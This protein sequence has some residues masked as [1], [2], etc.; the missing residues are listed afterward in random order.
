MNL[1]DMSGEDVKIH[2]DMLAIPQFDKVWKTYEDKDQSI[3]F[4]KYVILNNYPLSPYVKSYMSGDRRVLLEKEL[5]YDMSV[6]PDLLSETEQVF[7][8]LHDSLKAKLL[9][10]LRAAMEDFMSE[11][12]SGKIGLEKVIDLG[13]KAEKLIQSINKLEA[14][15]VMELA[16][17]SKI[18]GGYKIG[19]LEQRRA[20]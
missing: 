13:P 12:D 18:K 3:R 9:R 4:L 20:F 10:R 2:I 15:I 5:L 17:T 8:S 11:M 16:G 7:L 19:I 6:D 1:F 14:D